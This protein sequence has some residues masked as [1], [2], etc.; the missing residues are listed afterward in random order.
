MTLATS[1]VEPRSQSRSITV[2]DKSAGQRHF[3]DRDCFSITKPITAITVFGKTAGQSNHGRKHG[4]QTPSITET[5]FTK[6][7][8]DWFA[9]ATQTTRRTHL[10]GAP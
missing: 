8:R 6:G 4:N 9:A 1:L 7:F 2:A 3:L 5:P 10:N